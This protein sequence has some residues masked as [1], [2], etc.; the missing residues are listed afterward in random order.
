MN[1]A[2]GETSYPWI[3]FY[4]KLSI[5]KKLFFT[6]VLMTS[7]TFY[8]QL[9]ATTY[10]YAGF[11]NWNEV[12]NWDPSYPGKIIAGGDEVILDGICTLTDPV[13]LSFGATM[14]INSG[15]SLTFIP[16]VGEFTNDG[17]FFNNGTFD[18][19]KLFINYGLFSNNGVFNN[20]DVN[21]L[22]NNLGT[23]DNNGVVYSIS[24]V[25][26][27]STF[28]ND[29]GTLRGKGIFSGMSTLRG[30]IEP[31]GAG[32]TIFGTMS[33]LGNVNF[34][35]AIINI[36]LG[37]TTAGTQ[38]DLIT[39][40]NQADFTGSTINI[41][42][43]VEYMPPTPTPYRIL[44]FLSRIGSL[45][46][47]TLPPNVNFNWNIVWAATN[48]TVN[49]L[50]LPVEL[51]RFDAKQVGQQID[52][53]W[54]TASEMNNRGFEVQQC[55]EGIAWQNIGFV[56]GNGTTSTMREYRFKDMAVADGINYYRLKQVDLEGGFEYSPVVSVNFEN[57]YISNG[58]TMYPNPSSSYLNI[59]LEQ[60]SDFKLEIF[61]LDGVKVFEALNTTQL[62][63]DGLKNGTYLVHITY[64]NEVA[65]SQTAK[66]FVAH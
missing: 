42:L 49:A 56:E 5:M 32:A 66:L 60:P 48:A 44:T 6:L 11:G 59:L 40:S 37:G 55:K 54:A 23:F 20:Y 18:N 65:K 27:L 22:L 64:P 3:V 12:A 13:F 14:T 10:T 51:V 33:F 1:I 41:S 26:N 57:G 35:N 62:N 39:V 36:Q 31:S 24:S 38:F 8:T 30:I 61:T 28:D 58:V 2:M 9:S 21:S 15:A 52:L 25:V 16:G 43:A 53:T 50:V 17:T 45:P 46:T 19:W 29:Q 7:A 34:S 63:T 4:Q 47:T